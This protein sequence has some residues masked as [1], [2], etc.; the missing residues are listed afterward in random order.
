MDYN[1]QPILNL[2]A[3]YS[4]LRS[5]GWEAKGSTFLVTERQTR[6]IMGLALRRQVGIS[7]I[8]KP[9]PSELSRFDV[10]LFEQSE[11]WKNKFLTKLKD[12]FEMRGISKKSH[13]EIKNQE[14]PLPDPREREENTIPYTG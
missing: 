4:N 1:K 13:G 9:A 2:R 8:Q 14:P 11:A 6:Y 7:T 5:A 12:L 10:L 3:L